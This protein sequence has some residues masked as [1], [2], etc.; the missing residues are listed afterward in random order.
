MPIL[1]VTFNPLWGQ[2]TNPKVFDELMEYNTMINENKI[3][4]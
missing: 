2:T 1:K 4:R 3:F